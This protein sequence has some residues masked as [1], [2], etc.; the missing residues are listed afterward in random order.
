MLYFRNHRLAGLKDSLEIPCPVV[1][2][3]GP[4][5]TTLGVLEGLSE[6]REGAMHFS[7]I[8]LYIST[9]MPMVFVLGWSPSSRNADEKHSLAVMNV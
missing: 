3:Q 5:V 9:T 7:V 1:T 4:L 6:R 8:K 2:I